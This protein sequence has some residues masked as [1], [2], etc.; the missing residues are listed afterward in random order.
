M[1]F[2]FACSGSYFLCLFIVLIIIHRILRRQASS[3][4]EVPGLAWVLDLC[5]T[6]SNSKKL[7]KDVQSLQYVSFSLFS[8]LLLSL[9]VLSL[10]LLIFTFLLSVPY[11]PLKTVAKR[12]SRHC[13]AP[14]SWGGG[15]TG[16]TE[17]EMQIKKG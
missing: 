15:G 17:N 6:P 7:P 12:G 10:L 14:A 16:P 1:V 9:L 8:L 11:P 5:S 4:R 3:V 13:G 2:Y